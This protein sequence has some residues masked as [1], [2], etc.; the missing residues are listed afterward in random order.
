MFSPQCTS[1]FLY[2]MKFVAADKSQTQPVSGH[3]VDLQF[4]TQCIQLMTSSPVQKVALTY[5]V[6]GGA[7]DC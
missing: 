5:F 7:V 4:H 3:Y 6:T 2:I 1:V